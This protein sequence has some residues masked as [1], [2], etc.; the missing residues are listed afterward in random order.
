[1]VE[2]ERG[3]LGHGVWSRVVDGMGPWAHGAGAPAAC[4]ALR[5]SVDWVRA[6]PGSLGGR[7]GVEFDT[8][9]AGLDCPGC[10]LSQIF[11]LHHNHMNH[12]AKSEP[13]AP[14]H[15]WP[16]TLHVLRSAPRSRLG[17]LELWP[18]FEFRRKL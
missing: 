5:Y 3:G 13:A 6:G 15:R 11:G 10:T 2:R 7:G 8:W 17:Q 14:A 16:G 1:M 4:A 9:S 18:H 12:R